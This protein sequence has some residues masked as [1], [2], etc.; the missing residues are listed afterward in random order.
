MHAANHAPRFGES[1]VALRPAG[2][3]AVGGEFVFAKG[4]S[5]E[6]AFVFAQFKIDDPEAGQGGLG[7]LH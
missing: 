2:V 5:E 4:A 6:A 3:E 7:K 1:Q